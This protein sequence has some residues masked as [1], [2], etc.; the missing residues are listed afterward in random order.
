M[1]KARSAIRAEFLAGVLSMAIEHAGYGFSYALEY[2]Y[3]DGQPE[4]TRAL[5]TNRYEDDDRTV[6]AVTLDTIAAG[7]GVIR[8][9]VVQVDTRRPGDGPVL[10][11][12]RTGARLFLG[13]ADRKRILA[14]SAENEAADLDVIDALN[15]LECALF[16]TV[17]YA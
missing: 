15:I 12:A 13:T 17:V 5:I 14:A 7:I 1:A 6:Y 2:D 10:H 9:A 4:L 16:G 3:P 8:A 11:N